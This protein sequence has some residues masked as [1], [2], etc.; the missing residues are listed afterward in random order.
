MFCILNTETS[1][2][3]DRISLLRHRRYESFDMNNVLKSQKMRSNFSQHI[4][5]IFEPFKAN[6]CTIYYWIEI[7]QS[8]KLR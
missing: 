6:V 5:I 8:K 3:N 7:C 2:E 4:I 1:I